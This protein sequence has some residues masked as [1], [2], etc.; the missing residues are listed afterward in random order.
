MEEN[1]P[2]NPLDVRIQS[3]NRILLEQIA[4]ESRQPFSDANG[5]DQVRVL[6]LISRSNFN[7]SD[8]VAQ[9][10][11]TN[12]LSH[13]RCNSCFSETV[14]RDGAYV[15]QLTY[16]VPVSFLY[17]KGGEATAIFANRYQNI[18]PRIPTI[19]TFS[20]VLKS[21]FE[22]VVENR[23]WCDRCRRYRQFLTRTA[24]Q[25]VS[26]VLVLNTALEKS[27]ES[28][29]LWATPGWLPKEIGINIEKENFL[30]FEGETLRKLQRS[31]HK[32]TITIYQ[33]VG[34]VADI[35]SGEHEKPHLVSLIDS[36][37]GRQF[38]TMVQR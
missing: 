10:L 27:A 34:M 21:S 2:Q 12:V 7:W 16:Q 3:A 29:Q 30:C 25:G 14:R 6:I 5:L 22:R 28:R 26:P 38:S 15:H 19:P 18:H 4:L 24:L 32:N 11:V 13:I 35:I 31:L 20:S 23:A 36:W 9:I 1:S 37:F 8:S 17:P 33:L